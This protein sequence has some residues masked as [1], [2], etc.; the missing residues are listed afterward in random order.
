MQLEEIE[1][2][3]TSSL[4]VAVGN[5]KTH[6]PDE[7]LR[8]A[9]AAMYL[10]KDQGRDSW[11]IFDFE[12]HEKAKERLAIAN[13]L[14]TAVSNNEFKVMFQP[15]VDLKSRQI[16]GA[17]MLLRWYPSD[18]PVSPDKFIPLAE[19]NGTIISIG[20]WVYEQACL[21]QRELDLLPERARPQYLSVNISARQLSSPALVAT[22]KAIL[23]QTDADA[24]RI[25]IEV[26]ETSL[27]H[28]ID[29]NMD[30][31]FQIAALGHKVAVDDFGT[32]YS[33]LGR[34]VEMPVNILKVDRAFID[35]V[36]QTEKGRALVRA[37]ISM[38][39]ALGLKVIAEGMETK[40]ELDVLDELGCDNVQGYYFYRP[41]PFGAFLTILSGDLSGNA[42]L[43]NQR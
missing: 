4:G 33:S 7:L 17:E 20:A 1:L 3:A 8:N 38:S 39:R 35:G 5:G 10:A 13:G 14:R 12:I 42:A 6:L 27:M 11:K 23:S 30:V 37:I 28:D 32:G 25:V 40:A 26:T 24:S 22:F 2:Y 29:A 41:M 36:D 19:A 43:V 21:A 16:T 34:L 18:T 31:L 9:D 15:I